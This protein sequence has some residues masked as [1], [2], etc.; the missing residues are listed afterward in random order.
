MSQKPDGSRRVVLAYLSIGEAE[1]YRYYWQDSWIQNPPSWLKHE[2]ANWCGNHIVQFWHPEWKSIIY[3]APN[4]RESYLDKII[5]AGFDGVYLDR[6]DVY[7]EFEDVNAQARQEMIGFV[8]SL[9]T[10]AKEKSNQRGNS[11][12]FVV[13]QN[14]E[15]LLTSDTYRA[16]I[17]ALAKEDLLYGARENGKPNTEEEVKTS[18]RL[19]AKLLDDKKP[20]FG[21]EYLKSEPE[22]QGA[23]SRLSEL[24][25]IPLIAPRALDQPDVYDPTSKRTED[26][27]AEDE[28]TPEAETSPQ[29]RNTANTCPSK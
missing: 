6:I 7:S 26:E 21:V 24:G 10:A 3:A 5:E 9:S 22:M 11:T 17:D 4:G 27:S 14:A 8:K 19:I 13:A 25:L 1:N 28:A 20:V 18:T 12:F 2:N 16:H 29:R 23:R 15:E